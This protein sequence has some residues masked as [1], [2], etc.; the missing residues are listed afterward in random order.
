MLARFVISLALSA[1]L[2]ALAW[3]A[4]VIRD[5][6]EGPEPSLAD[7][8]GDASYRVEAHQ[9]IQQGA[10]GGRWCEHVRIRGNNGTAVYF[11]RPIGSARVIAELAP[12]VWVKADRG[13]IQLLA[14][15]VLP[16]SVD[17]RTGGP[18]TM[19]VRGSDYQ[20]VGT[21]Q[22][23]AIDN[24]PL[25]V[26]RQTRVLRTQFGPQVDPREA[27]LDRIL[28]NVYGG[29]GVTNV[30]VDD[31]E[32][33]GVV[34]AD[35]IGG[36]QPSTAPRQPPAGAALAESQPPAPWPG[37][38][39]VPKVELKSSLLLVDGRP[40]FPR[41]IEYRG[42]PLARLQSLGFNGVRVA[43][44]P[45]LGLLNEAAQAG[46]WIVAPPPS[47]RELE[48]REGAAAAATI[49]P[50]F[51]PVLA[52]DLG[53]GLATAELEATRRWARLVQAA[54]P[55]RRPLICDP[56]SDVRDYTRA[57]D[58]QVARREPLGTTMPL[59][60]YMDW[61]HSRARLA[62]AGTPLWA[63][64][65]TEPPPQLLE[66]MALLSGGQAPSVAPSEIQV[67]MLIHAAL[68]ARARGLVFT[69][70]DRLDRAD[71][72]AQRRS[73]IL[74]LV[75]LELDLIER[76]PASGNFVPGADTTDVNVTGAVIE[77]D[78]S[79]LLLPIYQPPGSQ[80]VM[81]NTAVGTLGFVVAGVPEGNNA[82]E[83][84]PTSFRPL[85]SRRVT[86][87]TRVA[88][89]EGD[90]RSLVAEY[91]SLVVFTRDDVVIRS[92]RTRIA[93]T[94]A[95][96]AELAREVANREL[97]DSEVTERRLA[98]M[99]RTAPGE[100]TARLRDAALKSLGQCEES[101]KSKQPGN[102]QTAYYQARYAQQ[103]LRILQRLHWEQ[104]VPPGTAPLVDPFTA[105]FVTLPEH[106]RFVHEAT[107]AARA[108]PLA[109]RGLRRPVSD[110][111]GRLAPLRAPAWRTGRSHRNRGPADFA[112]RAFAGQAPWRADEPAPGC[113][114]RR[115]QAQARSHRNAAAVD[116]ES[117]RVRRA[118]SDRANSRLDADQ[119]ADRRQRRR[120]A[121]GRHARARPAGGAGQ[122]RSRVARVH[123]LSRCAAQRPDGRDDRLVRLGRG[124]D[125]RRHDRSALS[126]PDGRA[127]PGPADAPREPGRR[128]AA[129][130]GWASH[131]DG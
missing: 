32:I 114:R 126:R 46:M 60:S 57:V 115:P 104:A 124:L 74:E 102:L 95:R 42:E 83:L 19:L 118:G 51:D 29:P 106:Y 3:A 122:A 111:G 17:Q 99:G 71:P 87:G 65:Q 7:L 125:R 96:A 41:L 84:S 89:G 43:G 2:P 127:C 49:G 18:L 101:L 39:G 109:R 37:G 112:G 48:A 13:G 92:L 82:Y 30:L 120:T 77:T 75:N 31:L 64:I 103:A 11:G 105:S 16:R 50:Q 72:A 70:R 81:G 129:V 66:Q 6:F 98:D 35:A 12:R 86:R 25:L 93:K 10:H 67:R 130:R 38:R 4:Q 107:R 36:T 24:L 78:R 80:L 47:A 22:Q 85:F 34:P 100:G 108:K 8:S 79:R 23:L 45:P 5:D 55:R 52:W 117:R 69:S 21:W 119:A 9:R 14:R 56:E 20:Q 33:V 90:E 97:V 73:A 123:L 62:R 28:L 88:L 110:A 53:A 68:A 121:G 1:A 54:D 61:L 94:Q 91:D 44:V 58:I 27:Y 59:A 15:I 131:F 76:W 128:A 113:R 26:E 63:A 116:H 40:Y